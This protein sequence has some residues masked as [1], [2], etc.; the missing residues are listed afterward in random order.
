MEG[1]RFEIDAKRKDGAL[2]EDDESEILI[3][4]MFMRA[5]QGSG[6][7]NTVRAPRNRRTRKAFFV[8]WSGNF[9]PIG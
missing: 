3:E 1:A 9:T 2:F 7:W 8:S 4:V 5:S 6:R